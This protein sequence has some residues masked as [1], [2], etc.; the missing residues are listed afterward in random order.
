LK[1]HGICLSSRTQSKTFIAKKG[2]EHERREEKK[3]ELEKRKE[4][5][6]QKHIILFLSESKNRVMMLLVKLLQ[7]LLLI[8]CKNLL[9]DNV[10]YDLQFMMLSTDDSDH[11]QNLNVPIMMSSSYT[12]A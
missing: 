4:L 1:N 9:I 5:H 7:S 11:E 3:R 2:R 6:L 10:L 12:G 8:L